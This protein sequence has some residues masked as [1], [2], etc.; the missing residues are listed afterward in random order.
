MAIRAAWAPRLRASCAE[1][2]Q[3]AWR[4]A[5]LA[6]EVG[7]V[8][9]AFL[10]A[11]PAEPCLRL[12]R[13]KDKAGSG[14]TKEPKQ[15]YPQILTRSEPRPIVP[16]GRPLGPRRRRRG[17]PRCRLRRR[18][19]FGRPGRRR[20]DLPMRRHDA[21]GSTSCTAGTSDRSWETGRSARL[22]RVTSTTSAKGSST[23]SACPCSS[24]WDPNVPALGTDGASPLGG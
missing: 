6:A 17:S 24:D 11:R 23:P 15:R 22:P 4:G 21:R 5:A 20:D 12:L 7:T 16:V 9:R 14:H 8:L 2:S 19:H 1:A 18:P 3:P 13:G 10:G